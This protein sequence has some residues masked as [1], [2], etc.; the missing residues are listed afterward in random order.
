[1]ASRRIEVYGSPV[2]RRKAAPVRDFGPDLR[3]LVQDMMDT[4]TTEEGAGLAAPQISKSWR[5][6]LLNL[7]QEGQK[8]VMTPMINPEILDS[9]GD[10]E[11]EE[12]CLSVPGIRETVVRPEWVR[13]RYQDL[14]GQFQVVRA[15]GVMARVVQHEVDH[16]DGILFVDRLTVSKR[17]LL[18]GKL[19]QL[20]REHV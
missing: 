16:L 4:V 8:P 3:R 18:S 6:I 17:S 15:D 11:F 19:K 9:G 13:V 5:V 7:P 14:R 12:G 10:S 20:S 2:L 1:M